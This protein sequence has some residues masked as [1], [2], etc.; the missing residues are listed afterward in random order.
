[1]DTR[2]T[3]DLIPNGRNIVVNEINRLKYC[4]LVADYKLNTQ[5]QKQ[6]YAFMSGLFELIQ[7]KWIRM[8]NEHE[9]GMPYFVYVLQVAA[10]D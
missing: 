10:F 3:V 9:L 8:F 5:I 4:Y 1:M 7:P 2:N 6:S